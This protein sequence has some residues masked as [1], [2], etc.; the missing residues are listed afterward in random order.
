[1]GT[2]L[3]PALTRSGS[4]VV[5][6]SLAKALLIAEGL[7]FSLLAA[8]MTLPSVSSASSAISKLKFGEVIGRK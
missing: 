6:R 7:R 1:M 3:R 4:P 5:L 2:R 8:P